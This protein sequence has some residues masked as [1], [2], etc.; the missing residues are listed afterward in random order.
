MHRIPSNL[1]GA[2]TANKNNSSSSSS[3]WSILAIAIVGAL[4]PAFI[5]WKL[6]AKE[7]C[8]IE[9]ERRLKEELESKEEDLMR[10]RSI[11]A[12]LEDLDMSSMND[13]ELQSLQML[14]SDKASEVMVEITKRALLRDAKNQAVCVVCIDQE[15][16]HT[17]LPC[18]H[19]CACADCAR[20]VL[21]RTRRCPLCRSPS[22]G[23]IQIYV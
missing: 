6:K 17:F 21:S 16:T 10:Q 19:R 20:Q 4:V 1:R 7:R 12:A 9:K 15:K 13:I 22:T 18:G 2:T 14:L 23:A 5:I 8:L 11:Q 3:S